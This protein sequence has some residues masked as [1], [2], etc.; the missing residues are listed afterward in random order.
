MLLVG[1]LN[2]AGTGKLIPKEPQRM[3]YDEQLLRKDADFAEAAA[4][5]QRR[6]GLRSVAAMRAIAHSFPDLYRRYLEEAGAKTRG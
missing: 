5:L 6:T 1:V 4:R 2:D 3:A